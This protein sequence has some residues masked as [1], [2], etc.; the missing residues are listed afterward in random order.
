MSIETRPEIDLKGFK[1]GDL[2]IVCQTDDYVVPGTRRRV[3]KWLATCEC[4]G[5]R[6]LSTSQV[7]GS[8]QV[9]QCRK[10]IG[11]PGAKATKNRG[12]EF[13]S[14]AVSWGIPK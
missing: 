2:T 1:S 7:R 11:N 10:C 5:E 4:G 9:T 3:V 14:P 6:T 13:L 8:R 12:S